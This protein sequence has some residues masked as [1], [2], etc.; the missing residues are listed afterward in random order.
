MHFICYAYGMH[1]RSRQLLARSR[2]E[3]RRRW[4]MCALPRYSVVT[5]CD[6]DYCKERPPSSTP[7]LAP[8]SATGYDATL[9]TS[10]RSPLPVGR[11]C[12]ELRAGFPRC[13]RQVARLWWRR[14]IVRLASAACSFVRLSAAGALRSS[15]GPP[16]GAVLIYLRV[17][18]ITGWCCGSPRQALT[19]SS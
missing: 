15:A 18:L 19:V 5:R 14:S 2:L 8:H 13:R 16:T 11:P 7:T 9:G 1:V 3:T 17:L 12:G 6:H 10:L 4:H